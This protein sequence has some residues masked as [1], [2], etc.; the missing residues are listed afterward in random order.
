MEK[1]K[2]FKERVRDVA[3]A[4]APKFKSEL[5]E[6]DYLVCSKAFELGYQIIKVE[7]DNF[8]HL[9]GVNSQLSA[10]DFWSK[11][12]DG[13]LVENDFEFKRKKQSE[14]SVKGSA[15][16][17][18]TV[19]QN[20]PDM[21]K[22]ELSAE[23]KFKKNRVECAFAASDEDFTLGFASSGRP[24]SLMKS[25]VLSDKAK[26]VDIV[27]R[28]HRHSEDLFELY[29]GDAELIAEY[30]PQIAEFIKFDAESDYPQ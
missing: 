15:R 27:F 11:C 19:L 18:I 20:V 26:D 8:M 25:N 29:F 23:E 3:V 9:V 16:E 12:L 7:E 2:S 30:L 4:V 13:T 24:K 6:Y 21:F 10:S 17:K 1:V 14:K 22:H 5:V 28:R